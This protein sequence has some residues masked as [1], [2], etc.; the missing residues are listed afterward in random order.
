MNLGNKI[1]ELRIQKG[2]TQEELAEKT[3]LNVRTIQ[4]IE[5]GEV[6]PR[7]YTLQ[8]IASA[9]EIQYN[10]LI[11]ESENE[12]DQPMEDKL[13]L[14]LLH[15]SGIFIFIF[16]PVIIW[17]LKKDTVKNMNKHAVDVIN[18]QISMFIYLI[19]AGL[20]SLVVIGIP[21]A[22]FLGLFSLVIVIINTIKVING[23]SY[24][25]P[26]SLQILNKQ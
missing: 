14:T 17:L 2:M 11:E 3:D 19:I 18:F 21:I 23:S 6:D 12:K 15:L 9:L 13:W 4:R 20:L 22:I 1:K 24:K 7:S 5:K 8:V 16:P 26:L 10:E 25:Y